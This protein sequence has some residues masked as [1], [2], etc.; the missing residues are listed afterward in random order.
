[1]SPQHR[2]QWHLGSLIGHTPQRL[3]PNR[4][5]WLPSHA[6]NIR[7]MA[8]RY[9]DGPLGS[10]KWLPSTCDLRFGGWDGTVTV[11]ETVMTMLQSRVFG[12]R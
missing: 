2:T 8:S 9:S 12:A 10:K 5:F 4:C 1:M 11:G 3:L 7:L 6:E